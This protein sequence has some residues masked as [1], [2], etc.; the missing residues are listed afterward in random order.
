MALC[1][2]CWFHCCV[3]RG[4][5]ELEGEKVETEGK[6]SKLGMCEDAETVNSKSFFHFFS[7]DSGPRLLVILGV[8]RVLEVSTGSAAYT[9]NLAQI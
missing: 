6:V 3:V 2:E 8:F 9:I 1:V 7:L 4:A 5:E